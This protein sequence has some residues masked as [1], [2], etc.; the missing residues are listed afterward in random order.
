MKHLSNLT[1]IYIFNVKF[2]TRASYADRNIHGVWLLYLSLVIP[3]I[4]CS[5]QDIQTAAEDYYYY[6]MDKVRC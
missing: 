5:P 3:T 1:M 6:V 2:T 4:Q